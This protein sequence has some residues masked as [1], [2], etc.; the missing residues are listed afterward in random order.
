MRENPTRDVGAG[1]V[2]GLRRAHAGRAGARAACGCA[3]VRRA[4]GRQAY[5]AGVRGRRASEQR[6]RQRAVAGARR[7]ARGSAAASREWTGE[8]RRVMRR[9][10]EAHRSQRSEPIRLTKPGR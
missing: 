2:H 7:R 9:R 8:E 5:R 4:H 6:A 10:R 3:S 1:Y